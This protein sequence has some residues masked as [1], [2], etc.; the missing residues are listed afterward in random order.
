MTTTQKTLCQRLGLMC[1]TLVGILTSSFL[2][3]HGNGHKVTFEDAQ[4]SSELTELVD[5]FGMGFS[6]DKLQGKTLLLNFIYTNCPG[7][8]PI[9]TAQLKTLQNQFSLTDGDQ[10][11]LLSVSVDPG[12]DTPKRLQAYAKA[13]GV[14]FEDWSFVTGPSTK[15][16][17]FIESFGAEVSVSSEGLLTHSLH[18]Y[19]IGKDGDVWQAYESVDIDRILLDMRSAHRLA[20]NG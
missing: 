14:T 17:Q 18:M 1:F 5:Q 9:Q 13:R 10:L 6:L 4:V 15:I 7:P 11:H 19:L 2:H 8:C 3:A 12:N 20:G 16:Q